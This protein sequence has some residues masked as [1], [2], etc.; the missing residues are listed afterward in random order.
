MT[1]TK[2]YACGLVALTGICAQED[3]LYKGNIQDTFHK[4]WEVTDTEKGI[5]DTISNYGIDGIVCSGTTV[6]MMAQGMKNYGR[7]VGAN[8]NSTSANNPNINFF[9]GAVDS[10]L[11]SVLCY[12]IADKGGHGVSILGYTTATVGEQTFDYILAADGWYDDAPRYVMYYPQLFES[13]TGIAYF[14]EKSA[15]N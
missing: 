2:K 7:V 3:I 10:N 5:Y 9:R 12:Q 14:V 11:S 8:I 15:A 4:L 6:Y 1:T 13:T